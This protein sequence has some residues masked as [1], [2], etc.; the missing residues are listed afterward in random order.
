MPVYALKVFLSFPLIICRTHCVFVLSV[1]LCMVHACASTSA[2]VW[3]DTQK[4]VNAISYISCGNVT[5]F[6]TSV[7]VGMKMN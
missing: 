5:E 2:S 3:D 6:V 1:H 7:Q 4:L